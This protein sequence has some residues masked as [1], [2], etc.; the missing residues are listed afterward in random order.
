MELSVPKYRI[1]AVMP[2]GIIQ[3]FVT[4]YRLWLKRTYQNRYDSPWKSNLG[5][6]LFLK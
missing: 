1:Q 2:Q 6:C 3:P 5:F 4:L